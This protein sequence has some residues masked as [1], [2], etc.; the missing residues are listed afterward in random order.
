VSSRR[1]CITQCDWLFAIS[2][3]IVVWCVHVQGGEGGWQCTD[4][5]SSSTLH[6]QVEALRCDPHCL[7][8]CLSGKNQALSF[9]APQQPSQQNRPCASNAATQPRTAVEAADSM[10]LTC[11]RMVDAPECVLRLL[12]HFQKRCCGNQG[13]WHREPGSVLWYGTETCC[14]SPRAGPA[15]LYSANTVVPL[16]TKLYSSLWLPWE[17]DAIPSADAVT[18]RVD[19]G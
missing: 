5:C 1:T 6:L 13:I 17:E 12:A 8:G 3:R 2:V 18:Q 16:A 14:P 7:H 10:L 15:D 11:P 19:F 9:H 4:D